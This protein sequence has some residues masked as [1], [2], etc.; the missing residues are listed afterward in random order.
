VQQ[1]Y[2]HEAVLAMNEDDD[3]HAPG[4]AITV[5]LCG[6]WRHEPPCPLAPHR[7]DARRTGP[8]VTIRLL[9]AAEPEDEDRVRVL[10]DEALTRGW[11][12]NPDGV[13]SH[14]QLMHSGPSDVRSDEED[15]A[16][17]LVHD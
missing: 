8:E 7:T 17:R 12:D 11:V 2:A 9:F 4:G 16:Q 6:S 1:A 5:A 15:Q 13:R 10:A 3:E 14:W